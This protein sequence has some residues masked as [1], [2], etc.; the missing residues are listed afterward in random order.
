MRN[1]FLDE[2]QLKLLGNPWQKDTPHIQLGVGLV[3]TNFCWV[4]IFTGVFCKQN[5]EQTLTP[6]P[7]LDILSDGLEK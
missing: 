2:S 5:A 7:A 1:C 6:L 4:S 3:E